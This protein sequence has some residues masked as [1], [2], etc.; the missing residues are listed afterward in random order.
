VSEI[1]DKKPI[2]LGFADHPPLQLIAQSQ[3]PASPRMAF[4]LPIG[5]LRR[6]QHAPPHEERR[7]VA[8]RRDLAGNHR[9]SGFSRDLALDTQNAR[10]I[11]SSPECRIIRSKQGA[12][13]SPL[14]SGQRLMCDSPA[15]TLDR[16][17]LHASSRSAVRFCSLKKFPT[18]R[19]DKGTG[20]KTTVRPFHRRLE[21]INRWPIW[22]A[23][24]L[25]AAAW[26]TFWR[27]GWACRPRPGL[28]GT[29]KERA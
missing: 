6:S 10:N 24:R 15:G 7:I 13:H 4:R 11:P 23:R 12:S 19:A 14:T 16:L 21:S 20:H 18:A 9:R 1:R 3:S 25:S 5:R 22:L 8:A 27:V 17:R 2:A 28:V 26:P 29:P